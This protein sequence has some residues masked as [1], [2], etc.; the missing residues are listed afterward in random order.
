MKAAFAMHVEDSLLASINVH[1]KG[2][3]RFWYGIPGSHVQQVD[4]LVQSTSDG[5]D[6][7]VRHKSTMIA[8]SILQ[9]NNIPFTKVSVHY[10][11]F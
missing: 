5:C 11:R 1:L 6:I 10:T 3:P 4:D 8:P 7:I 9:K 2:A